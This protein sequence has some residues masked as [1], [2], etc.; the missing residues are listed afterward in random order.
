MADEQ[1]ISY[2]NSCLASKVPIEKIKSDL[3]AAG[4]KKADVEEAISSVMGN[5]N[6]PAAKPQPAASQSPGSSRKK[7]YLIAAILVIAVGA[8]T[9]YLVS[10]YLLSGIPSG[11]NIIPV[12]TTFACPNGVCES[13]Q[14]ETYEL[15]PADCQ[16]PAQG[17]VSVSI[18]PPSASAG[19]G[20]SVNFDVEVASASNLYGFQFDVTY[21]PAG[22]QFERAA[23]GAF[24]SKN[25]VETLFCIDP[26]V[27]QGT[28][29]NRVTI[30]CTRLGPVGGVEGSGI[31]ETVTFRTLGSGAYELGLNK[32]KLVDSSAALINAE[33]SGPSTLTVSG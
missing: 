33:T 12:N 14:G 16:A 31:L 7:F 15:C 3:Y 19:T 28:P 2:I 18:K 1:L 17:T 11:A 27:T 26:K 24:L 29:S 23:Q 25:G 21:D 6:Q 13:A 30:A 22:L 4:W 20:E 5:N 8:T 9:Y 32:V 10:T